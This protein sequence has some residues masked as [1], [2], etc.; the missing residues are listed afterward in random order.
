EVRIPGAGRTRGL[1]KS[2]RRPCEEGS[3]RHQQGDPASD[4]GETSSPDWAT[5]GRAGYWRPGVS[6]QN[7]EIV[8]PVH[9]ALSAGDESALIGLIDPEIVWVQNPNA[10]DPRT[11]YGHDGVRE[12]AA[13]VDDAFDDLR[14]EPTEILEVA[15]RVLVLGQMKARGKGSGI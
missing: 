12:L 15:D 10:P 11:F 7:V 13:M 14:L 5:E 1:R 2:G 3:H 8:Q 9:G 6:Q 4:H